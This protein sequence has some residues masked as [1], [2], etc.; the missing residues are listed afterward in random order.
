MTGAGRLEIRR[1]V[2]GRPGLQ[3]VGLLG[4]LTQTVDGVIRTMN[5]AKQPHALLIHQGGWRED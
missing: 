3:K 2:T 5:F 4:P 1:P